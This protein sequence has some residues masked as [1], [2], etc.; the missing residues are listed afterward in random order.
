VADQ[1]TTTRYDRIAEGYARYWAPVIRPAAER[2][3]ELAAPAIAAGATEMIDIGTGTGTLALAALERWPAIWATGID[4]SSGMLELARDQA[5]RRLRGGLRRRYRTAVAFADRLPFG[6][7]EF[8]LALSSFVL[9]LVPNRAAALREAHR[10]LRPGS[11]FAWVTWLAG[12]V[13]FAGDVV[14]D[15]VLEE[16]GFD[17]PEPEGSSGDVASL[18]AAATAMR[19]AGFRDV[20]T[21]EAL[22]EHAWDVDG[23]VAFMTEFDEET[24][25][26]ELEA[27]EREEIVGRLRERLARL[28]QGELTL[29][30]PIVYVSG[31]AA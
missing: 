19:R 28:A 2:V 17:P 30:L 22:V 9:Q 11:T 15:A 29:R 26:A 5:S 3:L 13:R 14:T 4:P 8:D 20:H 21:T 23:Y 7:G 6:D 12:E 25:F 18:A 10:V 27:G 16:A 31:R 24:L 1:P